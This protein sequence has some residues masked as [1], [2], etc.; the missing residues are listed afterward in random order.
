[1]NN[2]QSTIHTRQ[3]Y[4]FLCLAY[5][6][7]TCLLCWLQVG[8]KYLWRHWFVNPNCERILRRCQFA[9]SQNSL[10]FRCLLPSSE[11]TE[12]NTHNTIILWGLFLVCSL[13]VCYVIRFTFKLVCYILNRT[14]E[15]F[16]YYDQ[17]SWLF[18]L[19]TK[20]LFQIIIKLFYNIYI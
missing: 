14:K 7:G 16:V 20:S 12:R 15:F 2:T 9:S 1:M 3:E 5:R 19:Y 11:K 6:R 18:Y 13:I 4:I 10:Y 17:V 8:Q